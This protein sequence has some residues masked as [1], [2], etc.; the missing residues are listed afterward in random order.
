MRKRS[1][2]CPV[3]PAMVRGIE[4]VEVAEMVRTVVV[5]PVEVPT[6]KNLL[7]SFQESNVASSTTV[8]VFG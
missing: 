3:S 1:E 5:A 7:A 2:V 4:S 8:S 6:I